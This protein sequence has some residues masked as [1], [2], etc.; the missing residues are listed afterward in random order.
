MNL[1]L[2]EI[3]KSFATKDVL[4]GISLDIK[5]GTAFGLLGRNGAGKTTTIRIIMR[6]FNANSGE[7]L[8]N[9]EPLAQTNLNFGY[10]PEE[11]G[12]YPKALIA[13]QLKYI[14][15]LRGM[16]G[17]DAAVS[18]AKWLER[19]E[20]SHEAN[21]K[22]ATLSK[23]NQQKVQ[24]VSALI[25]NPDVVILD[26]PFSGLDPVNSQV[27]KEIIN[28]QIG[29]DKIV[30]FS[31]HQMGYV[32]QFCDHVAIINNGEIV[33]NGNLRQIKRE[34]DRSKIKIDIGEGE[35][36]PLLQSESIQDLCKDLSA[37]NS[38]AII[39]LK[40]ADDAQKFLQ[41][42]ISQN[43]ALEKYEILEP[44]LEEI[45]IKKAGVQ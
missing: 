6:V 10:L 27:L 11:R 41:A 43:V 36:A 35:I 16:S 40:N 1:Q 33:L 18:A 34:G 8:L 30:L 38:T 39:T 21:K 23:G 15:Q 29:S 28:E 4:K 12:L 7:I 44:T 9:G 2:K 22:L 37:T 13:D 3:T 20:L 31:S 26:E 45:F 5:S 19:L 32:E 17:K 24:L 14:G 42:L 25:H